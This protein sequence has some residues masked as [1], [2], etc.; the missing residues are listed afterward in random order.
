MKSKHTS[1]AKLHSS[2]Q[3]GF[4]LSNIICFD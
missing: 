1:C 3:F 4:Q 2:T